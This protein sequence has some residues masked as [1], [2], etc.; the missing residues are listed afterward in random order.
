MTPSKSLT[1]SRLVH[2]HRGNQPRRCREPTTT[3]LAVVMPKARTA[4]G[5]EGANGEAT[6]SP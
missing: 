2:P 6:V 1:S 5:Q 4:A 3:E